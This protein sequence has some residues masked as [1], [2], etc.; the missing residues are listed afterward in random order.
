MD[1]RRDFRKIGNVESNAGR[2]IVPVFGHKSGETVLT[3]AHDCHF[4]ALG[5]EEV[6]HSA[7]YTRCCAD[8]EYVFVWEG[9]DGLS[10]VQVRKQC[11]CDQV[12]IGIVEFE[13]VDG[14]IEWRYVFH[15]C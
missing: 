12:G 7:T 10:R 13:F 1:E 14:R 5:N 11:E 4:D 2:F 9:H 8:E 3:A 6:G 15:S